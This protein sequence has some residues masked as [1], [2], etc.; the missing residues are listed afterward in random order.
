M[1][2][3]RPSFGLML[4]NRAAVLGY[5]SAGEL[6]DMAVAA[7]A[8][9]LFD[10][11]WSG[12]AFLVNPR[13]DAIALLSAVAARTERVLLG[14][15]CM[16]SFTQRGALDLA[17]GWAS[18]DWLSGG[19]TVMVACVGGGGGPAWEAEGRATGVAPADRR[20]WM[21]ERIQ[22]LR[23]LWSEDQVTFRGRFHNF[24]GV[25]IQPK[26]IRQPYP[27]WAAT[28]VTRL[29]TGTAQGGFP[30]KTLARIGAEC[31]GWMT[32]SVGPDAFG[33]AWSHIHQAAAGANRD[34]DA[35]DNCLCFN[36]CVDEDEGAALACSIAFLRDYYGIAFSPERT[37]EWTALGPPATCAARLREFAGSG[38]KRIL[39]RI[40][41]PDQM[42]QFRRVVNEVLPLV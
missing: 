8:S 4:S 25:T 11:V 1:S 13:L 10:S 41:N 17:Y 39:L 33:R 5:A 27:I 31:D 35:L 36:I 38:V 19:R 37:R 12:D 7:E 2:D 21:W 34:P 22:L 3:A 40:T 30:A 23:R 14:P 42:G 6:V 9:G 28:N 18:L 15:A 29:A 26:P 24:A 16:G 20:L 32:H